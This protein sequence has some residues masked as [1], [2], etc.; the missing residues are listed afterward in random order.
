[1]GVAGSVSG[2]NAAPP[3]TVAVT[4]ALRL[5]EL[6]LHVARFAHR[7]WYEH[8]LSDLD[9]AGAWCDE[10]GRLT[11][12]VEPQVSQWLLRE[13]GL[14]GQMDWTLDSPP[15]RLWLLDRPALE[16]LALELALAMHREWVVQIIDAARV[17]A[18]AAKVGAE[19]L[20]FVVQELPG[21]CLHYQ[22]PVASL[23][24]DLSR[25]DQELQDHGARTLV[26]LLDPAWRA[27]RARAQLFFDRALRL[28]DMPP[29]QPALS[30]RALDLIYG[31]LLPRRLPQW[32]WCC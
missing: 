10:Q 14:Q 11:P 4:R 3:A 6:N 31:Q 25:I 15:T 17:R 9:V 23:E 32:A 26:A 27:V 29:L 21:G 2:V 16:R 24:G 13:L 22:T 8:A 18:L 1:V 20:R 28:G 19:A 30:R 5:A 7:S 12:R